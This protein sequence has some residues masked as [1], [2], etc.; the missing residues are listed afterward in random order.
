[1]KQHLQGHFEN[2]T[3]TM[4][5]VIMAQRYIAEDKNISHTNGQNRGS[6]TPTN[7]PNHYSTFKTEQLNKNGSFQMKKKLIK[8]CR[9]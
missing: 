3:A 4:V 9:L 8:M 5:L 6:T 1:M 2:V 7:Q